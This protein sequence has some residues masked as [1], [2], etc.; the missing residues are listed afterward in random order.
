MSR[1][2]ENAGRRRVL[3]LSIAL[4]ALLFTAVFSIVFGIVKSMEIQTMRT[5]GTTSH[6][7][8]KEVDD[9]AIRTLAR[10]SRIVDY[11]VRQ[12]IGVSQDEKIPLEISYL[13]E[14]G[15]Q[16]MLMED[17]NGHFPRKKNE[18]VV[19]KQAVE[20][21]GYKGEI[22]EKIHLVYHV[23]DR[24]SSEVLARKNDDFVIA[25][26]YK[27]PVDSNVGVGQIYVSKAYADEQGVPSKNQEMEVRL[28]HSW[29]IRRQLRAIAKDAGYATSQ[30]PASAEEKTL[31]LGVN[32]A[33]FSNDENF[34]YTIFLPALAMVFLIF[35]SAYLI[36]HTV[37]ELSVAEDVRL[38]GLLKTLGMTKKQTRQ[39]LYFQGLMVDLPATVVGEV[40]GFAIS[41]MI[42]NRLFE[43]NAMLANV[44][45]DFA[46]F[47]GVG[48]VSA[49]V[50]VCTV[51]LSIF[52]PARLAEKVPP[53]HG[54]QYTDTVVGNYKNRRSFSLGRLA[55]REVFHRK[56]RFTSVVLSMALASIILTSVL[57]YTTNMD[58]KK[59]LS[60]TITT[61]YNV[62]SPAYFRY[63]YIG[64]D[65]ALDP[66]YCRKIEELPG[67]VGGGGIYGAGYES[68]Y[69]E[70]KIKGET[71]FSVLF[72]MDP[73]LVKKQS[74][75]E[76]RFD[77]KSWNE[78]DGVI[79]GV[80][81]GG[82]RT[83]SVGEK[84]HVTVKGE[85][86]E[87]T[88]MGKIPYNFSNGLR[89]FMEV[90]KDKDL[91]VSETN[92]ARDRV[93][94]YISP[95][96]YKAWMKNSSLMSYGF[97]IEKQSKKDFDDALD[98]MEKKADFSY[99][100][101]AKQE[102]SFE[103]TK[104]LIELAGYGLAFVLFLISVL[105]FINII[106]T[107]VLKSRRDLAILEAVGM[108]RKKLKVYLAAKTAIYSVCSFFAASFFMACVGN[109]LLKRAMKQ[110]MWLDVQSTW[111][112]LF[113]VHGVNAL[114]G[115]VF[116]LAYYESKSKKTL[117]DRV[118]D[119]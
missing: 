92:P 79:L 8:F 36:I 19:E 91:P 108:T 5:I 11:A 76:G 50:T 3:F 66:E 12:L 53:I 30:S 23:I 111:W 6:G 70:V 107:E 35:L 67:F 72:G 69:P 64:M 63:E 106:A 88:V 98:K 75:L 44:R 99:D 33:Y 52:R 119:L 105:N 118:R 86:R 7:S 89:Y 4:S 45:P 26:T 80:E 87:L 116:V 15:F 100:S 77:E 25:G 21:M 61:D 1:L 65:A 85:E 47:A 58:I 34:D 31:R 16:W 82:G 78:G 71:V 83:F 102:K 20:K 17:M 40:G 42:L 57:T 14:K 101:R 84:I 117:V 104:H 74:F 13:D 24:S 39:L 27:S 41:A 103:D 115:V 46:F 51:Y 112:P 59:G 68:A 28:K 49:V 97:D 9:K 109:S 2:R 81:Q 32:F 55:F 37:F 110:A 60:D 114:I 56:G 43:Q 95:K 96:S 94:L 29:R 62:A 22:G 90:G 113:L 10:D 38:I 48:I 18:I 54:A 73:Y 93:Y